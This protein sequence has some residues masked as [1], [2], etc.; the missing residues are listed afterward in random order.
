MIRLI[1]A[2]LLFLM[3]QNKKII[4]YKLIQLF[5]PLCLNYNWKMCQKGETKNQML[6]DIQMLNLKMLESKGS[7]LY[8]PKKEIRILVRA[9][10]YS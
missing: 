2:M 1:I 5:S 9:N 3:Q 7:I 10:C 6:N 8:W 4:K